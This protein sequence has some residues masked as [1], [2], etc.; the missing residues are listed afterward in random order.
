M[1]ALPP[2]SAALLTL[3]LAAQGAEAPV[4]KGKIEFNRDVRPILSDKCF[5]C[6]GPDSAARKADLRLDRREDALAEH[7][8]GRSIVPGKPDDS[9]LVHRIETTDE[10][11][12]M[13]PPKSNLK[14]SKT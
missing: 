4:A 6:H 1:T 9:A 12:I 14:L 13:P 5:K 2:I 11:E 3:A 7:D 8:S 10:D